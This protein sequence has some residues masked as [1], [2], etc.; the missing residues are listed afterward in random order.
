MFAKKS[1]P[2]AGKVIVVT[3][4]IS[5]A[6]QL[7]DGLKELGAVVVEFPTIVIDLLIAELPESIADSDW[8]VFTSANAVRGLKLS[9]EAS[10]R[11]FEFLNAKVC[12]V[13]PATERELKAEKVNVDL[14][15]D[16][17]TAEAT[18]EALSNKVDDLSGKRFLLPQGSIA[19][20]ALAKS[21]AEAGAEV[22]PVVVYETICPEPD[23]ERIQALVAIEPDLITFT[24]GSTAR[25]FVK[26]V[27]VDAFPNTAYASIGPHTTEVAESCGLTI[28]IQP[29]QH[30]I[31]RLINAITT[32]Y[33]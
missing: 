31:P 21:L 22:T 9:M 24:S 12:A 30:D 1:K 26:L 14:V 32:H 13:G 6:S 17:Y 27:D 7:A 2:L 4:A 28:T 16:T 25:N 5:Q 10:D 18:F 19:R 11:P 15:P 20:D 8:V 3:R 33:A 29:N 23:E